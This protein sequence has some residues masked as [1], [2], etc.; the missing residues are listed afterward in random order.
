M[1]TTHNCFCEPSGSHRLLYGR[2][3][4]GVHKKE[5]PIRE[6]EIPTGTRAPLPGTY[7]CHVNKS[8]RSERRRTPACAQRGVAGQQASP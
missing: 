6:A 1:W 2:G 4:G 8:G 7:C 5:T 3:S